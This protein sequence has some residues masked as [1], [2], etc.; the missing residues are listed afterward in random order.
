MTAVARNPV[1]ARLEEELR[2]RLGHQVL[3][4][5]RNQGQFDLVQMEEEIRK[6]W[7]DQAL[8]VH[9]KCETR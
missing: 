4:E 2:G 8:L 9:R 3:V 7:Q 5:V 1:D 6:Q